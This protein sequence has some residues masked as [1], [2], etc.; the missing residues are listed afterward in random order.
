MIEKVTSGAYPLSGRWQDNAPVIVKIGLDGLI[1]VTC[2]DEY[3]LTIPDTL[4]IVLESDRLAANARIADLESQVAEMQP[5]YEAV[6]GLEEWFPTI[7]GHAEI[8]GQVDDEGLYFECALCVLPE[9]WENKGDDHIIT[10]CV[11]DT[12][13]AALEAALKEMA[14]K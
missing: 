7:N 4:S 6:K 14:S 8:G 5:V 2:A 13:A 10:R 1:E 9:P 11:A 3:G 12:L